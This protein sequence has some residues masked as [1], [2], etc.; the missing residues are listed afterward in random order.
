MRPTA[1]FRSAAIALALGLPL[2][3]PASAQ[4]APPAAAKGQDEGLRAEISKSNAYTALM[5]RT[6]RAVESWRRYASWVDM[7]K[8]PTGKERYITYGMY[9]LYDVT[10]EISAAEAAT[11]AS[12]A[13]PEIDATVKRYIAAYQ[14]LAPLITR[15]ERYYER[16]DYRDDGAA[17][18]RKLHEGMVPAANAFLKERATLDEQ[19]RVYRRDLDGRELAAIETQEGKSARWQVRNIMINARAVID[20]L[21]SDDSPVVDMKAF[22][23]AVANYAGAIRAMDEFKDSGQKVSMIDSQASSWLGKVRDFRDKVAKTKGDARRARLGND[24]TWLVN[25]YNMMISM[26]DTAIRMSR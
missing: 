23:E 16:K 21:P 5:N 6:L 11:T 12:P 24:M 22:D 18:G 7:K 14:E 1:L 15:A 2:S 4:T 3:V 8:G 9:S 13:L 17:E 19:M 26:A 20:L 10:K 25:Q